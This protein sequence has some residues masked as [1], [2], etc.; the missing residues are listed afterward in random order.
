MSQMVS[1]SMPGGAGPEGGLA[2]GLLLVRA[3]T[4]KMMRLQLAM[5]RRDRAVALQAMDD[6]VEIDARIAALLDGRCGGEQL[7]AIAR[8][9]EDQRSALLREKFGLAAGFVRRGS[10]RPPWIESDAAA[11]APPAPVRTIDAAAIDAAA[12]DEAVPPDTLTGQD[13]WQ[14]ELPR[15]RR[16]TAMIAAMLIVTLFTAVAGAWLLG[17][18]IEAAVA[19]FNDAH[20]TG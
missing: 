10:E 1:S 13:Y 9:V 6:L 17:W 3:S 4:M 7:D 11:E 18:P 2:Q 20:L 15:P 16:R 8:E 14:A 19:R 5:E 12:P